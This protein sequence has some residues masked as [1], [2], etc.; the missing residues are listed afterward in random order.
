MRIQITKLPNNSKALGG[1]VQTHGSDFST[2]LVTIG[3]GG[4]HEDNPYDG[5]QIGVDNQNVPNLVEEGETIFN[6]YVFS[7]RIK[8]DATT[9]EKFHF[10]KKKDITYAEAAK[11]L[12]KEIAE[13]PNDHVS[14]AGFKAQMETLEEQQERQKAEMEAKRAEE[15]FEALSD[16]EKVAVMQQAAQEESARQNL[17]GL[18]EEQAMQ[19]M[20]GGAQSGAQVLP[21]EMPTG[22]AVGTVAPQEAMGQTVMAEGGHLFPWGGFENLFSVEPPYGASSTAG[23][24]PYD[25]KLIP[26]EVMKLEQEQRFIDWTKYVNDNWD[27]PDVQDYLRRLDAAAGGNHLF[28]AK[29]EPLSTGKD[30]FNKARTQNHLWG[31][32]HLTPTYTDQVNPLTDTISAEEDKPIQIVLDEGTRKALDD[33]I[34][35]DAKKVEKVAEEIG[36][37]MTIEPAGDAAGTGKETVKPVLRAEW[38]RYLGLFGPAVGLGMQ[39]AGIGKPKTGMLDSV[40][41]DYDKRGTRLA[42]WKP[43][44]NYL[45]YNPMDIW[46]EQNR[47]DANARATDRA[48]LNSASPS[49]IAGLLANGYNSQ[50]AS[51][52]LYRKALEYNDTKRHQVAEFNRGTDQYNSQAYNQNQ[53][54]NANA[55]NHSGQYRAGLAAQI[56]NQKMNADAG[57]YNSLYGNVGGLFKGLADLGR[58]NAERN[59]IARLA[60]SGALPGITPDNTINAGLVKSAAFGGKIKRKKSKRGLTI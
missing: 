26:E 16:K 18:G 41:A 46:F 27:K 60:A 29:G 45:T 6:S 34:A 39:L 20:A 5:V 51:G 21:E 7:N 12:E 15:A 9:K 42:K 40:L 37:G 38:P 2:G 48:I 44:G 30:Y 10:P 43:V 36:K 13:R 52:D 58:E 59:M 47:M 54:F 55:L 17:A 57:W 32:Y 19:E 33:T 22:D 8:C 49:R 53:Q 28:D 25:R 14:K 56:A 3:A 35:T 50:L 23:Y 1:V 11:K 4:T 31:Y 24:I